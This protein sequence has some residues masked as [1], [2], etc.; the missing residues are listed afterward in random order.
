MGDVIKI[1]NK[2][3]DRFKLSLDWIISEP[4]DYE[5]KYYT[6]LNFLKF[7]DDKIEKFELYPLFSEIS[8]HLANVQS[9]KNDLRYISLN[10]KFESLDDEIL[11]TELVFNKIENISE[12]ETQE[13]EKILDFSLEKFMQYFAIMKA[14]WTLAYDSISI[15]L[16]N[17]PSKI[18][19]GKGFFFSNIDGQKNLWYY[20]IPNKNTF[21]VD[22]KVLVENIFRGKS[23]MKVNNLIKKLNF[24]S[25]LPIFEVDCKTELPL[26]N[27]ILPV[28]K[29]K[30]LSYI[31]QTKTIVYLKNK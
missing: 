2:E 5:H 12:T 1:L 31:I 9:I 28:F 15:N 18:E 10:K 16:L 6:L 21:K 26:D 17:N 24:D 27:T 7:C 30:V 4:I 29:R 13:L 20:E 23:R 8:L 25:E 22:S 19:E 14:I 3:T 11:L